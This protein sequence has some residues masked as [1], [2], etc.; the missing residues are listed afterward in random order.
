MVHSCGTAG[1]PIVPD[2]SGPLVPSL[3]SPSSIPQNPVIPQD[4]SQPLD[5][6]QAVI[7]EGRIGDRLALI[8]RHKYIQRCYWP[9][10]QPLMSQRTH[11]QVRYIGQVSYRIRQ[12][13]VG[14]TSKFGT[15]V[16]NGTLIVRVT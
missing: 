8:I 1:S 4:S 2:E 9:D 6:P 16:S 14:F 10:P 12:F 13:L 3:D 11:L 5:P 15:I 7:P